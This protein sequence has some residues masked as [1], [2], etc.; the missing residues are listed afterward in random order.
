M[1]FDSV[2]CWQDRVTTTSLGRTCSHPADGDQGGPSHMYDREED[3]T[4]R[5]VYILGVP[6]PGTEWATCAG[7]GKREIS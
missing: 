6:S 5:R 2:T 4:Q 1:E 7:L 3:E